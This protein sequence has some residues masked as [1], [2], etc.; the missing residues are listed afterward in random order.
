M[1]EKREKTLQE[2]IAKNF[3]NKKEYDKFADKWNKTCNKVSGLLATDAESK[4]K[5]KLKIISRAKET[6]K[7]AIDDL[8][9]ELKSAS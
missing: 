4:R 3:I 8:D 2:L 5:Y 6:V 1:A 9:A 7:M